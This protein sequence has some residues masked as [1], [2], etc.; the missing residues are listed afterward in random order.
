MIKKLYYTLLS[1]TIILLTAGCEKVLDQKNLTAINPEDVW[2]DAG[3]AT[4]YV[5]GFHNALMPGM[6]AGTGNNT[7]EAVANNNFNVFL[8]GT[9]TIDSYNNWPYATIRTINTLLSSIDKGSIA[10]DKKEP[11]KGQAFFWRAWAYFSMVK[12]Y[13]GVPLIL[14]VQESSMSMDSLKVKRNSTSECFAQIVKD[15]DSAIAKLPP[16]WDNNN[17]GRVDKSA[18]MAFKA[19]ILLFYASPLF[20]PSGLA[21]R[22]Q[23]AYNAALAAKEYC[24]SQGKGLMDNFADIW[25]QQP[26]KEGIMV[27]V[28]ANPGATYFTGGLRPYK[29]SNGAAQDDGPSLE[30]VDAFPMIDGSKWNTLTMNHDT[31][32]RHRDERFYATI[33]YNGAAP[34]LA[35]MF[36]LNENL[37]TYIKPDGERMDG[38][39]CNTLSSFYRV[40]MMDR[41]ITQA[42]VSLTSTPWPEIR[43]AE[44]LMMFGEA[45]NEIGN[46]AEALQVLYDLRKRAGILPG[47]DNKYGITATTQETIRSAYQ[48][49]AF[50]EFAF[51]GKRW[52][53]LRRLRKFDTRFNE[54]KRRHGFQV[55]LK[56]GAPAPT[57]MDDINDYISSFDLVKV[58]TD[59]LD[60]NVKPEYYFYAIP[61]VHIDANPNLAQTKGWPGGT[62]DPLD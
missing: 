12:G 48:D 35:D 28:Y 10:A 41:K 29:Y 38:T 34:Y 37:W 25:D 7:D 56:E 20:N 47:T 57:G 16:S 14:D 23:D 42:T 22:W 13:G 61:K 21:S 40:K 60:F 31:L 62:F 59:V 19:R 30:L 39:C 45:A 17:Y 58:A 50:V 54:L 52:D 46:T 49:E 2:N 33:G 32:F 27:R 5:N 8:Y 15:V 43:F 18:A 51:E 26:N 53:Y 44:L 11:L 1:F 36:T 4:A 6:P 24:E 3:L 9:A 55:Y